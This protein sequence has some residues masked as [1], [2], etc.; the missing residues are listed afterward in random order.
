MRSETKYVHICEVCGRREILTAE[1][2]FERGWDHP[3]ITCDFGVIM[4]RKCGNCSI[5]ETV[6]WALCVENTP[7]RKLSIKHWITIL[8]IADEPESITVSVIEEER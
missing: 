7:L 8:R 1:E 2:G 4:P 3:P 5:K 6:W